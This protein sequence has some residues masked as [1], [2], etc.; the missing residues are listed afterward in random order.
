[1]GELLALMR[2]SVCLDGSR[3]SIVGRCDDSGNSGAVF[4]RGGDF[5]P[6]LLDLVE[7]GLVGHGLGVDDIFFY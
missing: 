4:G 7:N 3:S 1:M 6:D 5:L 2:L